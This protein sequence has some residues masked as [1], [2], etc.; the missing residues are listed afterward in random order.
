[1]YVSEFKSDRTQTEKMDIVYCFSIQ[2]ERIKT[3]QYSPLGFL[4][5]KSTNRG[6]SR[7]V[8]LNRN[9]LRIITGIFGIDYGRIN[10]GHIRVF[11]RKL[12]GF[13]REVYVTAD[14]K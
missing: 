5:Y 6:I 10:H 7:F 12:Y 11:W 1:M 4:K 2:H 13:I 14:R 9:R 3:A 8:G